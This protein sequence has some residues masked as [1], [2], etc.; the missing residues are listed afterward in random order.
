[1]LNKD[2]SSLQLQILDLY[3]AN[4]ARKLHSMVNRI[5]FRF[6]GLTNKDLDD[7]YSLAN[8][9]FTDALRRYDKSYSFDSFLYSCLSNKIMSEMTKRNCEKRKADR[10]SISL[11][12]PVGDEDGLTIQD[13]LAGNFDMEKEIF[14]EI[15]AITFK[16]EKYLAMLSKRQR[17]VLELLS[18]CYKAAEIQKIMHITQKEYA[19]IL[20]CIHSYE[21]IKIL[22]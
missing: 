16:L 18:Y 2:L 11:D 4:N 1:M 8:E 7:F 19:E 22:L 15:N 3:Y 17:I 13:I 5:L 20:E 12:T 21:K 6:G 10:M 9:V 14:G